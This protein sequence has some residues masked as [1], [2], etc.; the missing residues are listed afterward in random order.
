MT[1]YEQHACGSPAYAATAAPL[2][3][4]GC[5]VAAQLRDGDGKPRLGDHS[6]GRSGHKN[7]RYL[8]N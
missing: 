5:H 2:V 6:P 8:Y 4:Q 7:S 3:R 1:T